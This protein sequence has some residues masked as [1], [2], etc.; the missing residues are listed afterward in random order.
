MPRPR[1]VPLIMSPSASS[2]RIAALVKQVPVVEEL[3]LD[4]TGR[5]RREGIAT[6]M[7]AYGRRAVALGVVLARDTGGSCTVFTLGPPSAEDC[8]REALACGADRGVLVSDPAFAGSDTLATAR[9]LVAALAHEGPFDLVLCGRNSVDAETG[10]VGPQVAELADLPFVTGVRR[11][12][13]AGA[14]TL[15]VGCEHDDAWVEAEVDLPAVCSTAERLIDPCKIKDPT[16]WATIPADRITRLDADRLGPGPWGATA[17]PTRVGATRELAVHR[18]REVLTGTVEA[19]VAEAVDH[20]VAAGALGGSP[21]PR[22]G[23]MPSVPAH[24]EPPTDGRRVAVLVEP[25]RGRLTRELLGRGAV[26]AEV[27]GG[28]V[29]ALVADPPDTPAETLVGWG[30]DEVVHFVGPAAPDD[31]TVAVSAWALETEPWALLGPAT[32][33][34]REVVARVAAR[35]G[36]GLTGDAVDLSVVDGRLVAAKPAF[37][38]RIVA[39]ITATGPIQAATVRPGVLP[40]LVPRPER[41]PH[42]RAVRTVERRGR[43]RIGLSRREDDV[44]RLAAAEVVLGVGRGVD[45]ERYGELEGLRR[46]LGAELAAT[47]K[48][49]D[50]GWMARAR[51]VGITGRTVSPRLFVAVGASGKAYHSIGFRTAGFVLGINPDPDAPLRDWA[52]VVVT[53]PW[54]EAVP[55]LEGALDQVLGDRGPGDRSES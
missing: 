8:L 32:S 14:R 9:A 24:R 7:D 46:R 17:S 38:G 43:V 13:L 18:R 21:G 36:S 31:L 37:G 29:V 20:M 6:E 22:P 26:L 16:V 35:T 52:D 50:Q 10:Q 39:D 30:A 51:Q 49:T 28:G 34:G 11:V 19:Q 54:E 45:P 40:A 44:E 42:H 53:A 48:V 1:E 15:E 55:A 4:P 23:G 33:W 25:D 41:P 3:E 27:V 47:R 5:L 12:A 2:L